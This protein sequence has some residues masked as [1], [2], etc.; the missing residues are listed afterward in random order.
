M[1]VERGTYDTQLRMLTDQLVSL[2]E[3][4]K[5]VHTTD[6]ILEGFIREL[7]EDP[8]RFECPEDPVI[9]V[10]NVRE[11]LRGVRKTT[12][13]LD[14]AVRKLRHACAKFGL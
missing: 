9:L 8:Q 13:E 4:R 2:M 7:E 6:K 3:G 12:Q 11:A 5:K 10:V 1:K 14:E